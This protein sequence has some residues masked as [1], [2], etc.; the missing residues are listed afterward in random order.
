MNLYE[1][2]HA[3]FA[4]DCKDAVAKGSL[5]GVSAE[6]MAYL[7]A[8]SAQ[9]EFEFSRRVH[10][11]LATPVGNVVYRGLI[12]ICEGRE[13]DRNAEGAEG[14]WGNGH[15]WAQRLSQLAQASE[16]VAQ[17]LER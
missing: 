1:A 5:T 4:P 16:D 10:S 13:V 12:K 9:E 8:N 7:L 2:L 17:A 6:E 15:H 14:Y 3:A 11:E